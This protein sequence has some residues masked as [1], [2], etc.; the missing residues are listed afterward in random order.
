MGLHDDTSGNV[1]THYAENISRFAI[2]LPFY[3]SK[4][5]I[6]E[7]E[8]ITITTT[9]ESLWSILVHSRGAAVYLET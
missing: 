4:V 8:N 6:E 3:S 1:E 5:Y 7:L 9:E 2:P